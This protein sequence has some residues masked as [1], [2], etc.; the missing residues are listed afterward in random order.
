MTEIR[1]CGQGVDHRAYQQNGTLKH[2]ALRLFPPAIF[3]TPEARGCCAVSGS[4]P[5]IA[6]V[7]AGLVCVV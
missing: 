5:G 7:Q 1:V 4:G 3:L 2:T 6:P